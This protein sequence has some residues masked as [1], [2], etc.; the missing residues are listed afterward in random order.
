[1]RRFDQ[2]Q[3]YKPFITRCVVVQGKGFEIG[4]V[5]EVDLKSG[6]PATKSTER[7]EFLDDEQ[8]ILSI[9]IL[10]G[11]HRLKVIVDSV[12]CT[13]SFFFQQDYGF[14]YA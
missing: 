9:R 5:R 1:M 12:K 4:T 13:W 14:L 6:L 8:H 10:G 3:K 7:L 2:P 11:D